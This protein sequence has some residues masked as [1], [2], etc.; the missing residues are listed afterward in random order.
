[1]VLEIWNCAILP[2]LEPKNGTSTE[3]QTLNCILVMN[4]TLKKHTT[5]VICSRSNAILDCCINMKK[6]T[7]QFTNFLICDINGWLKWFIFSIHM[8]LLQFNLLFNGKHH[9]NC[10][11]SRGKK[12]NFTGIM[13]GTF[14]FRTLCVSDIVLM[15][16]FLFQVPRFSIQIQV[17]ANFY[18]LYVSHCLL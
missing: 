18:Y 5:I 3:L 10:T 7:W 12:D 15:F 17:K 16:R 9:I 11:A 14:E 8:R 2:F 1:M 6:R 13:L 4:N